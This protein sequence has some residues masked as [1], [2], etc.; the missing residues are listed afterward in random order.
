[1]EAVLFSRDLI[2]VILCALASVFAIAGTIGLYRFP[3]VYTR[4]QAS[5]L[6]G[7][8]AVFTSFLAAL[9]VSPS[10]AVAA[11]VAVIILFFLLSNPTTTHIIA[12]YAWQS[13]IEPVFPGKLDD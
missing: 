11:R 10:F 1:M 5:S 2:V 12:Q 13:G 6:A 7:T 9:L 4:L 3:D 8:T